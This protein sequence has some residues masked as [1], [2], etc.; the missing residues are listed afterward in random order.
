MSGFFIFSAVFTSSSFIFALKRI[1]SQTA[2]QFP[3]HPLTLDATSLITSLS[4]LIKSSVGSSSSVSTLYL[5]RSTN[6]FSSKGSFCQCFLTS[7]ILTTLLNE[8]NPSGVFIGFA[9]TII[10]VALKLVA[11]TLRSL[12]TLS[13]TPY[14]EAPW[15]VPATTFARAP[16]LIAS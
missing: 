10:S 16:I 14:G 5:I 13:K 1:L 7:E 2:S 12:T 11:G 4:P 3:A 8:C 6:P 15:I 9:I